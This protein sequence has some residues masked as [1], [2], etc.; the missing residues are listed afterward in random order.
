M[1]LLEF[2]VT[3]GKKWKG[4][5]M[6]YHRVTLNRWTQFNDKIVEEFELEQPY[7]EFEREWKA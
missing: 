7:E 4:D 3:G 2:F 5:I 6:Y 1:S